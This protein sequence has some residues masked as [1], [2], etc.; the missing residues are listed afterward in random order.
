[1]AKRKTKKIA[2]PILKEP[3]KINREEFYTK[4]AERIKSLRKEKGHNN[5]EHFA[6]Y[7]EVASLTFWKL[8]NGKGDFKMETLLSVLEGLGIGIEEFFTDF[9]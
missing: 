7:I 6:N 9:D 3:V 4:V 2:A 1:M 5:Y 8:E